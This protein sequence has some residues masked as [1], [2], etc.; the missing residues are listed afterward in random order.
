M[1]RKILSVGLIIGYMDGLAA[2]INGYLSFGAMPSGIFRYIASGFW[3]SQAL[4][5]GLSMILIGILI[6]FFIAI[7]VTGIFFFLYAK[8]FSLKRYYLFYGALYGILV[9][10]VMNYI[11][12]PL[13]AISPSN[14]EVI[15]AAIGLMIHIFV[16]GV[17]ISFFASREYA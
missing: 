15:Q 1:I 13:S 4:S 17:P 5:G 2:C 12:I 8:V 3:G 6:H 9:W 7:V 11:V 16:I 10:I 14:P